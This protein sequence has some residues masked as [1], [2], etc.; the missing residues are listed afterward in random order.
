MQVRETSW[1]VRMR[2]GVRR[3]Y[4]PHKKLI[5]LGFIYF[6]NLQYRTLHCL[7]NCMFTRS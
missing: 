1:P 3:R 2:F 5:H 7:N 6:I 4:S